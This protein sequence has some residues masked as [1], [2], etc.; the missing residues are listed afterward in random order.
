MNRYDLNFKQ[1]NLPAP[2]WVTGIYFLFDGDEIVYV[3]QS[4]DIMTRIG[5]HLRDKIFDSFNYIECGLRDLNNLEATYILEL[6]PKYN[7]TLP[8]NDFW[9]SS[10]AIKQKHGIGKRDL[11]KIIKE[12]KIEFRDFLGVLYVKKGK[13]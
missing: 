10:N 11:K 5:A 13:K 4:V 7:T 12:E 9:M 3:G 1:S 8:K 2:K 6:K